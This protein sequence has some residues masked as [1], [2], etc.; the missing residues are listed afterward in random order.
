MKTRLIASL[1]TLGLI[2]VCGMLPAQVLIPTTQ[3]GR[4]LAEPSPALV[5]VTQ[6]VLAEP[7]VAVGLAA[8]TKCMQTGNSLVCDVVRASAIRAD[9]EA[10]TQRAVYQLY[11]KAGVDEA[12]AA[13]A[14]EKLWLVRP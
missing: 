13:L 1:I 10:R 9:M 5:I 4:V 11:L 7:D 6:G 12:N 3:N 8:F 2:L 14:A